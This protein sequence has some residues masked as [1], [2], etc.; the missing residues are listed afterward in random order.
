[1]A[2]LRVLRTWGIYSPIGQIKLE[3]AHEQRAL[4]CQFL[5]WLELL[6]L[7]P[8]SV[9]GLRQLTK[10]NTEVWP[11][12]SL[13]ILV[14]VTS[15]LTYGNGRF[16]IAAEPALLILGSAG[17]LTHTDRLRRLLVQLPV[18]RSGCGRAI[19]RRVGR[20]AWRGSARTSCPAGT[21]LTPIGALRARPGRHRRTP[22][23][24]IVR[25][26]VSSHPVPR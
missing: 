18:V 13:P 15:A 6:A 9:L 1:L 5:G 2:A 23:P 25:P 26:D 20:G 22:G 21:D 3:T 12:L 17:L 24:G 11:L 14:T 8:L 10:N 16:R 4:V 7:L 19:G